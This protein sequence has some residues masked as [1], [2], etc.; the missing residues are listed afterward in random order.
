[1]KFQALNVVKS[2]IDMFT[3]L[4]SNVMKEQLTK[5]TELR[6]WKGACEFANCSM[7]SD[8]DLHIF[9]DILP[10][11]NECDQLSVTPSP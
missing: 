5:K 11:D 1:M 7:Q 9:H 6:H 3:V 8:V 10:E 4:A 2:P